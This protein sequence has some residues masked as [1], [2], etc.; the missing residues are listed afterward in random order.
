MLVALLAGLSPAFGQDT[1]AAR[2]EGRTV[3]RIEFEPQQQ[4]LPLEEL[5]RLLPFKAG[6]ALRMDQVR[7]A[8]QKLYTTGRYSDISIQADPEGTGVALHIST[9]LTYFISGVNISGESE[10][11]NRNQ[12]ITASKLELGGLFV[13]ADLDQAVRISGQAAGEWLYNGVQ[14]RGPA[15]KH[16]RPTSISRSPPAP[17]RTSMA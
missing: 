4:P 9:V 11:P 16:P 8:I 2:W 12:L 3:S 15:P 14:H 6:D 1:L 13:D 17:G 5:S 10:P 7:I